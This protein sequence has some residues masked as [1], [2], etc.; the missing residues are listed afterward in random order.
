ML[1]RMSTLAVAARWILV[2]P[3]SLVAGQLAEWLAYVSVV[4]TYGRPEWLVEYAFVGVWMGTCFSLGTVWAAA[5]IAPSRK[6]ATG[7]VVAAGI[8]AV[9]ALTT[10]AVVFVL[11]TEFDTVSFGW[12][13]SDIEDENLAS[14]RWVASFGTCGCL[15]IQMLRGKLKFP[16]RR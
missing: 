16:G 7:M 15:L 8:F 1:A 2:L 12:Y 3:G 11:V 14:F 6:T 9:G 4:W 10:A 5:F 13:P